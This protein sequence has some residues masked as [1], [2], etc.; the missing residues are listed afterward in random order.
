MG[1][2]ILNDLW[3]NRFA[4]ENNVYK[5]ESI[6]N[7]VWQYFPNNAIMLII[8]LAKKVEKHNM[9]NICFIEPP[10]SILNIIGPATSIKVKIMINKMN[11]LPWLNKEVLVCIL[12][13]EPT[14]PTG[15]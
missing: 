10:C 3:Y 9:L 13:A 2:Y 14:T 1:K 4:Y 6:A 15:L 11:C 5:V 7:I 8:I 12:I